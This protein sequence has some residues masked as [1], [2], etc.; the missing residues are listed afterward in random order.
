MEI[1]KMQ[2][3]ITIIKQEFVEG[4]VKYINESTLPPFLIEYILRDTLNEVHLASVQQL[5]FDTERY[6]KQI[7]EN[8]KNND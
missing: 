3:P 1:I 5:K 2:K 4:L 7:S 8:K 6:Q